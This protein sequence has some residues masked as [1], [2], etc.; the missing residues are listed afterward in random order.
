MN[1]PVTAVTSF[2]PNTP[3]SSSIIRWNAII[4]GSIVALAL[5]GM[6]YTLGLA[7]GLSSITPDDVT[8]VKR[9]GIFTGVWSILSPLVALFCGGIFAS[10]GAGSKTTSGGVMHGL[11]MWA[12]S[13]VAFAWLFVNLIGSVMDGAVGAG[14][15]ALSL[16]GRSVASSLQGAE[17]LQSAAGNITQLLGDNLGLDVNDALRPINERLQAAGRDPIKPQQIA[18]A[19][20]NVARQGLKDGKV[21]SEMLTKAVLDNT[22]LERRD[23]DEISQR[24]QTQ[25]QASREKMYDAMAQAKQ[26]AQEGAYATADVTGKAFWAIFTVLFMGM[27]AGIGG[28]LLGV[29]RR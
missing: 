27:L 6:L 7:L 1:T 14:K 28:G 19:A 16:S 25:F 21:D 10:R 13:A 26:K 20:K 22:P 4:A 5:W 11:V 17:A 3:T 9:S 18:E 23:A 15:Q 29:D 8:S 12:L 2:G 24:L